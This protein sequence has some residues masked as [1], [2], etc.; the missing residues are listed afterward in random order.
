MPYSASLL[1]CLTGVFMLWSKV[2]SAPRGGSCVHQRGLDADQRTTC[3]Q[4]GGSARVEQ[5]YSLQNKM[6]WP[7][8]SI[9]ISS[10]ILLLAASQSP[11]HSSFFI[12]LILA[13]LRKFLALTKVV[14][15]SHLKKFWNNELPQKG[16]RSSIFLQ[17]HIQTL[18]QLN[19]MEDRN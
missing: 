16:L 12:I 4:V 19:R 1:N 2:H 18:K 10:I 13:E 5:G 8:R 11:L 3:G 15:V 17:T 14:K 9:K 6:N 7:V